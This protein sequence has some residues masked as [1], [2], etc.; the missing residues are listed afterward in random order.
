[1]FVVILNLFQKP[2]VNKI[3]SSAW[4]LKQVQYDNAIK[5][6]TLIELLVVVLIIG[7]LSSVALP[8]YTKAV[9]KSRASEAVTLLKSI[10]DAKEVYFMSI[11]SFPSTFADLDLSFTSSNG[12]TATG[13]SFE[14]KHFTYYLNDSY[15]CD[16]SGNNSGNPVAAEPKDSSHKYILLYCPSKGVLCE[17][18]PSSGNP[19]EG[20][21]CKRIGFSRKADGDWGPNCISAACWAM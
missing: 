20:T 17:N 18:S 3:K 1:M 7:I 19:T 6:F 21:N 8:Q 15:S 14:T 11:G 4:I 5:G 9:E 16:Y 12:S 2:V 10:G 13:S